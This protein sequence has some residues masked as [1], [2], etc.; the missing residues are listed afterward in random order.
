MASPH[1]CW[2]YIHAQCKNSVLLWHLRG[3]P[4]SFHSMYVDRLWNTYWPLIKTTPSLEIHLINA[5]FLTAQ[6]N[7]S[8]MI[9][10]HKPPQKMKSP[11]KKKKS[12]KKISKKKG[13]ERNSSKKTRCLWFLRSI[14]ADG[15]DCASF[16]T[17]TQKAGNSKINPR[18]PRSLF[19][20]K[21][22]QQGLPPQSPLPPGVVHC[23]SGEQLDNSIVTNAS[24]NNNNN[25]NVKRSRRLRLLIQRQ[26]EERLRK[27]EEEVKRQFDSHNASS[28]SSSSKSKKNYKINTALADD[29]SVELVPSP[30]SVVAFDDV[31]YKMKRMEL[32]PIGEDGPNNNS[33]TNDDTNRNAGPIDI[34]TCSPHLPSQMTETER[35]NLAAMHTLGYT[36]LR[37]N[38]ITNAITIFTEILRGQKERHG[39]HSLQAAMAMHNLGV[40]YVKSHKYYE[41]SKLCEMASKIRREELGKN[42]LDVAVSL[43]QMG[44]ALMKLSKYEDALVVFR[45]ALRIRRLNLGQDCNH[46][47]IVRI[48]NNIGCALFELEKMEEAR[49][50]FEETL[51]MQRELMKEDGEKDNGGKEKKVNLAKGRSGGSGSEASSSGGTDKKKEHHMLL[52]IALTLCN[53]GSIHLRTGQL[54]AT[55]AVEA[56]P[57]SSKGQEQEQEKDSILFGLFDNY[58]TCNVNIAEEIE[59]WVEETKRFQDSVHCSEIS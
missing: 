18:S 42:H 26:E 7:Q 29:A 37:N 1:K 6:L 36:H 25:S 40:V 2:S 11:Q 57:E 13:I 3:C 56:K 38:E 46:T 49:A 30:T 22:E 34:D 47:L 39:K 52:S 20:G 23:N 24:N 33:T 51:C 54:D 5:S 12:V 44:V 35:R 43:A 16:S 50:A 32:A 14:V 55:D 17:N 28:S 4:A 31:S 19:R 27:Q 45:E 15:W 59:A 10:A 41:T 8:A 48:L 9:S 58:L 21:K 53:L